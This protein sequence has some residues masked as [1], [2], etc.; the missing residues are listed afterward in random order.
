MSAALDEAEA[1]ER[2]RQAALACAKVLAVQGYIT[3]DAIAPVAEMYGGAIWA[4]HKTGRE[5]G[6]AEGLA[7]GRAQGGAAAAAQAGA[8]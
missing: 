4:G 2:A 3:R 7:E 8:N 5:A 1:Q 6:R